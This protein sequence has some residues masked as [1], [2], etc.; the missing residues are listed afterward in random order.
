MKTKEILQIIAW[1]L[2]AFVIGL[3]I[4]GVITTLK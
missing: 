1:I 4:Y 2:G 3:A